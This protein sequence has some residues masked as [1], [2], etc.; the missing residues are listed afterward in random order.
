MSDVMIISPHP[1]DAEICMGGTIVNMVKHKLDV[2]LVDLTNGEPTPYG[3]PKRRIKEAKEAENILRVK[4][5]INLGLP[6]RTLEDT[7]EARVLVANQV[8]KFKPTILFAPHRTDVH[9]DH[10]EAF[11]IAQKSRFYAKLHKAK[12]LGLKWRPHFPR[13]IFFYYSFHQMRQVEISFIVDISQTFWDKMDSI[14]AYRSQFIENKKN[15][16]LLPRIKEH[17]KY[18]GS[19]I[20]CEYGEPFYTEAPMM[21]RNVKELIGDNNT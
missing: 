5:R 19:L 4:K 3:T 1:D 18:Y 20:G 9:P 12:Y 16:A 10:I 13:K 6:N 17:F 11:Q 14:K 15:K 7:K 21:I 2:V 8:R